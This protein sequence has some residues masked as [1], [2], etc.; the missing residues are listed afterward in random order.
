MRLSCVFIFGRPLTFSFVVYKII[1]IIIFIK[2]SLT[3]EESRQR[4]AQTRQRATKALVESLGGTGGSSGG[5]GGSDVNG[6]ELTRRRL[7][8]AIEAAVFE[9]CERRINNDYTL[10]VRSLQFNL[11]QN[12][13]LRA[14]VLGASMTPRE[15]VAMK[16]A[17]LAPTELVAL[18]QQLQRD[19]LQANVLSKEAAF[20]KFKGF[21]AIDAV[22]IIPAAVDQAVLQ[23]ANAAAAAAAAAGAKPEKLRLVPRAGNAS[24]ATITN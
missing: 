1:I 23:E 19:S 5:T 13:S 21:K 10:K 2:P 11:K 4:D 12:E 8:E 18:T 20:E 14:Q 6:G 22:R 7:G 9:R 17:Q 15:L 24:G 3:P 16:P